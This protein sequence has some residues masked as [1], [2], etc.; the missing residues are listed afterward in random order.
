MTFLLLP[1]TRLILYQATSRTLKVYPLKGEELITLTNFTHSKTIIS[2]LKTVNVYDTAELKTVKDI[3]EVKDVVSVSFTKKIDGLAHNNKDTIY[4]SDKFGDIYSIGLKGEI[5]Y[6]NSNLGIP[7]LLSYFSI[8][9]KAYIAVGDE[10]TRI[11]IYN[12]A[13]MH[14]IKSFWFLTKKI[15]L[16]L[17][18]TNNQTIVLLIKKQ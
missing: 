14:Q 2:L 4:V 17:I 18:Q 7:T 12:E 13:R 9:N 8:N 10:D 11:K 3:S 5:K 6:L 15:P 16:Q 1:S